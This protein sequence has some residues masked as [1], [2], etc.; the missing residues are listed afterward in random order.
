MRRNLI[1]LLAALFVSGAMAATIEQPLADAAK[2]QQ[3]QVLFRE[4]RC[5]VCEGQTIAD[6]DATMAGQMRAH[7]REM[8]AAGKSPDDV[9]S[10]FRT[11]YGEQILMTP[12]LE[13]HTA[14]LWFLPLL[15]LV[16]GGVT[17]WRVTRHAPKEES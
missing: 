12:P 4:L 10:S 15:L 8:L 7:V 16:I 11:S 1:A 9:L 3:A 5:V 2:E 17:V 6:S 14:L 13:E